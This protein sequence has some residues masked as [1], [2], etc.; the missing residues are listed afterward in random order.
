MNTLGVSPE[1]LRRRLD[2][3]REQ[4]AGV[5][6][7]SF[8]TTDID[9]RAVADAASRVRIVDFFWCDPRPDLVRLAHKG[10]ALVNWQV[11]SAAE[12]RA[13]VRAGA[14]MVSA[15]GVE[16]G[17]HCRGDT[18]LLPLLC[19]VLDAVDVPVLAAEASPTPVASPLLS[20]R[21]PR[22][23]GWGRGS[24]PQMN[25]ERIPTTSPRSSR[26]ARTARASPMRSTTVR[27]ARRRRAPACSSRQSTLS[28]QSTSKSSARCRARTG[29]CPY[30]AAP[31]YRRPEG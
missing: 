15:Q 14:D 19:E 6:A 1:T 12:A 7:V 22:A 17:G 9:T 8:L 24:S 2:E 25:R 5:L 28:R 27:C 10:G 29:R 31:G 3:M 30:R 26:Q 16:A 4:T 11:G 21:E 23:C 20:L 13:A 18:P